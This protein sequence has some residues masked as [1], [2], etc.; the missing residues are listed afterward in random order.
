MLKIIRYDL[1]HFY[2]D[3]IIANSGT[4]GDWIDETLIP[5]HLGVKFSERLAK[6]I[7]LKKQ[8][9]GLL[10]SASPGRLETGQ[11]ALNTIFNGYDD[12]VTVPAIHAI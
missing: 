4:V 8:G 1:L 3:N 12:T 6:G 9:M 7:S 5:E 2:R 10:N 11:A